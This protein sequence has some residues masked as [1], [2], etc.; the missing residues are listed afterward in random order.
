MSVKIK[1]QKLSAFLAIL[2][3]LILFLIL[4]VDSQES[5]GWMTSEINAELNKL[6]SEIEKGNYNS[7]LKTLDNTNPTH[8]PIIFRGL[9]NDKLIE[10]W[11]KMEVKKSDGSVDSV[12]T[13]SYRQML[14]IGVEDGKGRGDL[15]IGALIGKNSGI[16]DFEFSG[17]KNSKETKVNGDFIDFKDSAGDVHKVPLKEFAGFKKIFFSEVKGGGKGYAV[18][19]VFEKGSESGVVLS[20]GYLKGDNKKGYDIIDIIDNKI[21]T[22]GHVSFGESPDGAIYFRGVPKEV[23]AE[24]FSK[25][26]YIFHK[27][28]REGDISFKDEMGVLESS[29]RDILNSVG[30]M[31]GYQSEDGLR[32]IKKLDINGDNAPDKIIDIIHQNG[33]GVKYGN[34]VIGV[35]SNKK[36][37]IKERGED[38]ELIFP[39]EIR[40]L[41]VVNNNGKVFSRN[42]LLQEVY[43]GKG[44]ALKIV[45]GKT[46]NGVMVNRQ[47]SDA[48]AGSG[49]INSGNVPFLQIVPDNQGNIPGQIPVPVPGQTSGL[50]PGQQ[51]PGQTPGQ[52]PGQQIPGQGIPG[53]D[54][55]K[56]LIKDLIERNR[57]I[58]Q[59]Q[60]NLQNQQN[61]PIKNPLDYQ[62]F[63]LINSARAK[64]NRRALQWD[65]EMSRKAS[66]YS[67]IMSTRS[68]LVHSGMGYAENIAMFTSYQQL[69]P[70]QVGQ[71]LS[72][73]WLSSSGH[74]SNLMN[75]RHTKTGVGVYV[76]NNGGRYTYYATQ[77]FR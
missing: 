63:S 29:K 14:L 26:D 41:E 17:L 64:Q 7:L 23:G 1:T 27:P 11:N 19:Y 2:A 59:Y 73:M 65:A 34:K 37:E 52:V 25:G 40:N 28:G 49:R 9:T 51:I 18:H 47:D 75:S 77:I 36:I 10:I 45:S 68:G 71:K 22:A 60:Q 58:Q 21:K 70:E 46:V 55:N 35:S 62:T 48:G 6:R 66:E 57:L 72:S 38:I 74:Y 44:E 4:I 32:G 15:F 56:D 42:N 8:L 54:A 16:K 33:I 76:R 20:K 43:A 53:A 3:V 24:K 12:K 13:N 30:G 5:R 67:K 69:S 50:I 39:S 31:V 61:N